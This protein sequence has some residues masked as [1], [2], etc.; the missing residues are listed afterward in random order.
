MGVNHETAPVQV[1]EHFAVSTETQGEKARHIVALST[2]GESVVISTCN[3]TEVYAAAEHADVG[4]EYLREYMR[5]PPTSQLCSRP[6]Y[7]APSH[8]ASPH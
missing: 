8:P 3:R 4:L 2:I 7:H 5:L 6:Q 1:R